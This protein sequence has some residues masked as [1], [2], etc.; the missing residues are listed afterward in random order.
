MDKKI[1]VLWLTSTAS[2]YQPIGKVT[3]QY[4]GCGWL[5]SADKA[6]S[7]SND[8]E[9]A[10]SFL[11]NGQPQKVTQGNVVYYPIKNFP[12][13]KFSRLCYYW[14]MVTGKGIAYD[15]STWGYYKLQLQKV[16][17]DFK[18]DIV[19]VWGS[20]NYLGL[21]GLIAKCPVVL[22]IQGILNPYMNAFLPPSFNWSDFVD[23]SIHP[24]KFL[25]SSLI[26]RTMLLSHPYDE[27]LP[28]ASDYKF[29]I[30]CLI[31]HNCS[32]RPID[33][34]ISNYE[35]GGRSSYA[36]DVEETRLIYQQLIPRRILDDYIEWV[37]CYKK[38]GKYIMPIL[39]WIASIL[40]SR[41]QFLLK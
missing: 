11:L 39:K 3:H 2:N 5:Q 6:I 13:T 8:V 38:P 37:C 16:L 25:K 40:K 35:Y 1:K 28:I 22:H 31:V 9:L 32:Y 15:E 12:H 7:S 34:V 20:E 23:Y 24:M 18:P 36:K 17:D 10:V 26:K 14:A 19:H 33:V 21:V 29:N 41:Y 27:N 30:E 4:N